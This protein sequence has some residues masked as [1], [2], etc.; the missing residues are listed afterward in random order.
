MQEWVGTQQ[1]YAAWFQGVGSVLAI[2]IAILLPR[3]ERRVE[4]RHRRKSAI[5][6]VRFANTALVT[7]LNV[8]GRTESLRRELKGQTAAVS[9]RMARTSL[10]A[11][12][13]SEYGSDAMI[14]FMAIHSHINAVEREIEQVRSDVSSD[15]F[16]PRY[17]AGQPARLKRYVATCEGI[18]KAETAFLRLMASA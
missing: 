4:R 13:V 1:V 7:A 17:I 6:A 8:Y 3:I 14:G 15:D 16:W 18:Q 9:L 5:A 12:P 2:L 10:E 11:I